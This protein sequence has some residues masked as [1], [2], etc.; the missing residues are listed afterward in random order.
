MQAPRDT[1]TPRPRAGRRIYKA[2]G[3]GNDYLVVEAG[4]DWLADEAGSRAVCDRHEG[5]GSD[6]VVVLLGRDRPFRLRMFNPDGSEFE[7]SGNGLR[8]LASYLHRE[9]LVADEAFEVEVGGDRVTMQVHGVEQGEY[10][11]SVA[12]GRARTG[13]EAVALEPRRL[14]DDGILRLAGSGPLTAVGVS[15]GNPHCVIWGDPFEFPSLTRAALDR[16]GPR[17]ST[18]G[19][20]ANG[21]NVQLA[22]VLAPDRIE[23]LVWERGAGH[24]TASGTSACAVAVSAVTTGRVAPGEKRIEMEGGSLTVTVTAE[25]E[26]T[27]RGPVQAVWA[28]ELDAGLTAR[29]AG[30]RP[31]R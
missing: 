21:V 19:A 20:F 29:L 5:A 25:L 15:V 31:T 11:V 6:G 1:R 2:H 17:V 4:D 7:R 27:L 3:L 12:M 26:V 28:G 14:D 18:D 24:T 9:G 16:L 23:A 13:A 8:V 10:D 30:G 22:R